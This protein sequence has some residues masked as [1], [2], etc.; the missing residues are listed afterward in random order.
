[1]C[2]QKQETSIALGILQLSVLMYTF[3]I[4]PKCN[5]MWIGSALDYEKKTKSFP[6]T[7]RARNAHKEIACIIFLLR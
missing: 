1:M 7:R 5:L 6:H 2:Q 3:K 4:I